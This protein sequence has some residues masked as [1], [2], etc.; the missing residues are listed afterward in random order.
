MSFSEKHAPR[1]PEPSEGDRSLASLATRAFRE[2]GLKA[3]KNFGQNFLVDRGVA[4]RIAELAAYEEGG[5]V[6]E[7]GAGLGALTEPLLRRAARVVAIERDRDLCPILREIFAEP[8]SQGRL[9]VREADAKQIDVGAELA[10]APAPRVVAGNLPYQLTGPLLERTT[11]LGRT[12]D[13]AVF[14]VQSE[15]AERLAA[16]PASDAYGALSIFVGAGFRVSRAFAVGSGAFHPRPGVESAVVVLT[17][18]LPPRAE[19]TDA[20]RGAVRAAFAQRRKTLRNAWRALGPPAV[21]AASADAVG[22]DLDRRGETLSVEEFARFA[23]E[24]ARRAG[25]PR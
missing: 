6:V 1:E 10:G 13:R 18:L 20:F 16:E 4:G 5:T 9:I 21:I 12:I 15:V 22:I 14:M 8:I 11:S 23:S 25:A 17:P 2:R 7:V 3:K 19:E 24:L